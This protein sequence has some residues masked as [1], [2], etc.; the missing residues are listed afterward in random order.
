MNSRI[1]WGV[2]VLAVSAGCETAR[3]GTVAPPLPVIPETAEVRRSIGVPGVR[4]SVGGRPEVADAASALL[5][6]ELSRLG[7]RVVGAD[8]LE[9]LVAD[10]RGGIGG[11]V[12]GAPLTAAEAAD[13]G[14]RVGVE[15]VLSCSLFRCEVEESENSVDIPVP[16]FGDIETTRR[17]I[18]VQAGLEARLIDVATGRTVWVGRGYAEGSG[19]SERLLGRSPG[20][21]IAGGA[22]RQL[23]AEMIPHLRRQPWTALVTHT[24]ARGVYVNAGR[25]SGLAVGDRLMLLRSAA[26]ERPD[27]RD[28]LPAEGPDLLGRLEILEVGERHAVARP[29][30]GAPA[31]PGDFVRGER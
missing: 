15:F 21:S 6:G 20:N 28:G 13:L 31:R 23:T 19:R 4:D 8:R 9:P 29:L 24:D 5:A 27:P 7:L 14:R 17:R 2:V 11:L 26:G 3:R 16:F 10:R 18:R 12:E 22:V 30:D 1:S 25:N